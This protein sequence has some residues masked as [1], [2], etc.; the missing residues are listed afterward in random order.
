MRLIFPSNG[1]AKF[2]P[3]NTTAKFVIKLPEELTYAGEWEVG[4]EEIQY[5]HSWV[6]VPAGEVWMTYRH[7]GRIRTATVETG[8]F[9]SGRRLLAAFHRAFRSVKGFR[10]RASIDFDSRDEKAHMVLPVGAVVQFSES[11]KSLSG[12]TREAYT[13]LPGNVTYY[14]ERPVDLGRGLY[15]LYVY[16]DLIEPHVVGMPPSSLAYS[17]STGTRRRPG[18]GDVRQ[19]SVLPPPP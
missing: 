14:G 7:G 8:L 12:Y 16:C 2:F 9:T 10:E 13:G 4:L 11:A 19:S 17:A 5:P 18:D 15:S 6:N 3:K 1:S